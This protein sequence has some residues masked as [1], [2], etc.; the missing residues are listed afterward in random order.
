MEGG[1]K[2]MIY[3]LTF[4]AY[5]CFAVFANYFQLKHAYRNNDQ[6]L[7]EWYEEYPIDFAVMF[8]IDPVWPGELYR[9]LYYFWQVYRGNY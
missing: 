2:T 5:Y 4:C 6:F 7:Q 8:F 3:I 9:N 1:I